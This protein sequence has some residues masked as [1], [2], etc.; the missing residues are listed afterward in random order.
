MSS[1]EFGNRRSREYFWHD[2]SDSDDSNYDTYDHDFS[3]VTRTVRNE[4]ESISN[5]INMSEFLNDSNK[6]KLIKTILSLVEISKKFVSL[7][8][9]LRDRFYGKHNYDSDAKEKYES[10]LK[11]LSLKWFDILLSDAVDTIDGLRSAIESS[12]S[13]IGSGLDYLCA[14]ARNGWGHKEGALECLRRNTIEIAD[15]DLLKDLRWLMNEPPIAKHARCMYL[16]KNENNNIKLVEKFALIIEEHESYARI[17]HR[18]YNETKSLEF[19]IK[20]IKSVLSLKQYDIYSLNETFQF[21]I[22]LQDHAFQ[23]WAKNQ[24]LVEKKKFEVSHIMALLIM[25]CTHIYRAYSLE[26]NSPEKGKALFTSYLLMLDL[27]SLT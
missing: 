23:T 24:D 20:A 19:L 26:E 10:V 5:N 9:N 3:N 18:R 12:L 27:P 11:V 15:L 25:W 22:E 16:M 7:E 6:I 2:E 21:L 14:I 4:L 17:L 1:Y 13:G 8:Y